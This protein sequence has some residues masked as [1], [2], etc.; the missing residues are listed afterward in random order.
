MKEIQMRNVTK[1]YNKYN[2]GFT[3]ALGDFTNS[4][5]IT[6]R[7]NCTFGSSAILGYKSGVQGPSRVVP[8]RNHT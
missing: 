6:E 7:L 1:R 8:L 3:F 5:D 2:T 4:K